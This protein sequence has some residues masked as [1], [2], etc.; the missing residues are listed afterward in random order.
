MP[1]TKLF[2]AALLLLTFSLIAASQIRADGTPSGITSYEYEFDGN[3][4]TWELPTNPVITS[5]NA[6][7]GMYFTISDLSF[8]ENGVAMIGT[9]D[10]YNTSMLGGFDLLSGGSY[11][12]DADGPQLYTGPESAPT[13]LG[14]NF[15]LYD[16]GNGN[17]A[18]F[19]N[20][21]LAA[22]TVPEPSTLSFVA[23]GLA[24]G[25]ALTILRK[26]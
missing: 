14:G 22:T 1:L 5:N 16:F 7:P 19:G 15:S 8:S 4:F 25:L 11:L 18:T 23:V 24:M 20:T 3:N 13:L 9:I 26:K 12:C 2:S 17:P 10:F 21:T 6:T